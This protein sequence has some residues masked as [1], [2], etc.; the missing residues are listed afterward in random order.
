[1]EKTKPEGLPKDWIEITSLSLNRFKD[2]PFVTFWNR[3]YGYDHPNITLYCRRGDKASQFLGWPAFAVEIDFTTLSNFTVISLIRG[4][5]KEINEEIGKRW[6]CVSYTIRS[7]K[8][9]SYLEGGYTDEALA[10]LLDDLRSRGI[11]KV[12]L[13]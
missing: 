5:E 11:T 3:K 8:E 1:M 10:N 6:D 7:E 9:D 12:Y 4:A 2:Y 13:G